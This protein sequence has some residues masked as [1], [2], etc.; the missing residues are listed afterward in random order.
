MDSARHR[1]SATIASQ[2]NNI[3]ARILLGEVAKKTG[4]RS[5]AIAQYRA[6][7][8]LDQGSLIAL[9]DLAF[10][11]SQ[12]S[13]GEALKYAQRAGEIAPD[14]AAVEDTLGW[15]YY[16]NGIYNSAIQY[17]KTSVEKARTPLR[18]YHLAMAYLKSGDVYRGQELLHTALAADPALATEAR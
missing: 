9:N 7:L 18:E 1:L 15:V 11:L 5:T 10:M 14:N 16:R 3:T 4:D 6:I 13:P 8:A 12:E 2:P 17:L